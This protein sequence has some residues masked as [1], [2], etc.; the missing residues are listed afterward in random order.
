MT[1]RKIM[2]EK[3]ILI[4]F[5]AV[6]AAQDIRNHTIS[7]WFLCFGIFVGILLHWGNF[8]TL[9]AGVFPGICLCLI[10]HF[11]PE[12]IGAGDGWMLMGT[13]VIA[14]WR[15]TLLLLQNGL[16]LMLPVALFWGVV[17]KERKRELPFA[18]F[19]MGGYLCQLILESI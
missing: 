3:G 17:K 10:S 14:G 7:F 6:C 11:L 1:E 18:P 16:F 2:T 19:V 8:I 15:E 13:G 9:F 4:L 5:L 12:H